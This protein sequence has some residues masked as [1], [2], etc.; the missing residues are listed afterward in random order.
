[1]YYNIKY[2]F[3][4]SYFCKSLEKYNYLMLYNMYRFV[5]N[6]ILAICA[7]MHHCLASYNDTMLLTV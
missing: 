2:F 7:I 5:Q 6:A 3:L 1:M 4:N